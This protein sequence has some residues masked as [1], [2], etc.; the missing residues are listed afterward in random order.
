MVAGAR[1]KKDGGGPTSSSRPSAPG[2]PLGLPSPATAAAAA[3]ESRRT[4]WATH[5]QWRLAGVGGRQLTGSLCV[6]WPGAVAAGGHGPYRSSHLRGPEKKKKS[7]ESL[8]MLVAV[9]ALVLLF[10]IIMCIVTSHM[11][12]KRLEHKK[13]GGGKA[14]QGSRPSV[15]EKDERLD[16]GYGEDDEEDEDDDAVE[17]EDGVDNPFKRCR[18]YQGREQE[19][20]EQQRSLLHGSVEMITRKIEYGGGRTRAQ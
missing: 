2:S 10:S 1:K 17:L 18:F 19:E 20:E 4:G 5:C 13:G 15:V 14:A 11:R 16:G 6:C 12:A 3:G 9:V 8:V 7:P